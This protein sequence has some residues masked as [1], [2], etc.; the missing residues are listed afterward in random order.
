MAYVKPDNSAHWY[1]GDGEP[2]HTRDNGK[3]TTLKDA[4]VEGLFPSVTSILN[5]MSKPALESWKIEQGI[6]SALRLE[7]GEDESTDKFAKRIVADMKVATS[8]AATFGT[9]VHNALEHYNIDRT[10]PQ[11]DDEVYPWFVEYKPWFDQNITKVH[12]AE[13]VLVNQQHGYAGTVDLVADHILWGKCVIDFKTQ[14]VKY[15]P[16]F[17][18][19]WVYQLAAYQQCI[20]GDTQCVSLIID[21]KAPSEPV[22]KIWGTDE[23]KDGWEIFKL[24]NQL[25]QKT[26]NYT[27]PL[28]EAF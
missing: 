6:L 2:R 17:Y 1:T 25:Y 23:V 20:E 22:E 4:R 8:V 10:E 26:K 5:I 21:S 27:P 9:K 13:T 7:Q 28:K 24:S 12:Q 19:T 18:E 15:K 16:R 3:P 14:G 11:E